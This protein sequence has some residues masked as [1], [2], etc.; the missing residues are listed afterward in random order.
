MSEMKEQF[1]SVLYGGAAKFTADV[2]SGKYPIPPLVPGRQHRQFNDGQQVRFVPG[3]GKE[4]LILFIQN[5]ENMNGYWRY[6]LVDA[7]GRGI[8]FARQDDLQPVGG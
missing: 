3:T 7:D 8:C 2:R 4:N 1:G 5:G 6:S